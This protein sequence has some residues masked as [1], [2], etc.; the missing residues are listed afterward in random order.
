MKKVIIM[1]AFAALLCS[2]E[3]FQ[4]VFTVEYDNPKEYKPVVMEPTMTILELK[5]LYKGTPVNFDNDDPG[6]ISG[7][8]TSSD[9]TGNFYKSIYIQDESSGIEVKLGKYNLCNEYKIGQRVYVKI[10]DL[11][12]GAYYEQI[13]LGFKDQSGQYETSYLEVQSLIDRH[14]FRG[15]MESKLDPEVYTT[16]PA[17]GD[18]AAQG[19]LVTLKNVVYSKYIFTMLYPDPNRP[20]TKENPE[21]RV[22]LSD[23][24]MWGVTTWSLSEEAC[25]RHLLAGDWDSA[26]VKSGPTSFGA[27]TSAVKADGMF[28][29]YVAA[30]KDRGET[31]T[32]KMMLYNNAADQSITQ[33]FKV[34]S[35][36]LGI[37]TSGYAKFNEVEIPADVLD[38]SRAIDVTGVLTWYSSEP[39]W[40]LTIGSLDDVVYSD[41]GKKLYE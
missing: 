25:R 21:N 9:S 22:F 23:K 37:R 35:G 15:K 33:Y 39:V 34:G 38:G 29:D 30:Y 5:K 1:A 16:L 3:E 26:E 31:L 8:V 4:P 18:L 10:S 11:T 24:K 41:N 6:I 13:Q 14:V 19:T 12:L 17:N 20:H 7:I 40:Q 36:S 32:Y 2:C 28:A 27:I